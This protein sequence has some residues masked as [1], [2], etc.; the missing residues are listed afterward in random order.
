MEYVRWYQVITV[1]RGAWGGRG[2]VFTGEG[3][4][5][6]RVVREGV[7]EKGAFKQSWEGVSHITGQRK[8]TPGR[9]NSWCTDPE[10]RGRRGKTG[11]Q[12]AGAAGLLYAVPPE[13]A[14][15]QCSLS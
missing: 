10:V 13:A 14:V 6:H 15:P 5:F 4:K 9:G 11:S 8:S 12:A 1:K 2:L 7:A 3:R